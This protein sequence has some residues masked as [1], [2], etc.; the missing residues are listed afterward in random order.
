MVEERKKAPKDK[1]DADDSDD[2]EDVS[3]DDWDDKDI[4][5]MPDADMPKLQD[6]LEQADNLDNDVDITTPQSSTFDIVDEKLGDP[7]KSASITIES[8]SNSSIANP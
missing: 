2:Y 1:K 3:E 5:T 8:A 7:S 6:V 4:E